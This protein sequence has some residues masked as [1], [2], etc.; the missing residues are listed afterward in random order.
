MAGVEPAVPRRLHL[1]RTYDHHLHS[2]QLPPRF[3]LPCHPF[4]K[5]ITFGLCGC[6]P[7]DGP[8]AGKSVRFHV[9]ANPYSVAHTTPSE[10]VVPLARL[11]RA[12]TPSS[13][14]DGLSR[15]WQRLLVGVIPSD[16]WECGLG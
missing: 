1:P 4:P 6:H 2:I 12:A 5:R 16:L 3:P 15:V 9:L 8:L 13:S 14:S 7:L 10:V 11:E